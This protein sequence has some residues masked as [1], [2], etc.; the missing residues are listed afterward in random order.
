MLFHFLAQG[1]DHADHGLQP[2]VQLGQQG[3]GGGMYTF[4]VI[5][6]RPTV[7]DAQGRQSK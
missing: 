6:Y 4:D 7:G 1:L 2:Q 3:H 5:L